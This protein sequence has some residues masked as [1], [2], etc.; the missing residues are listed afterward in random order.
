MIAA[1]INK[2]QELCKPHFIQLGEEHYVVDSDGRP[3]PIRLAVDYAEAIELYSLDALVR[4][5]ET[6]ALNLYSTPIYIEASDYDSVDCFLQP[7]GDLRFVRQELYNVAAKDIPG[8]KEEDSLPFEQALIAVRT[9]FQRS[10][11]TAYLLKLLSEISNGAKVTFA[12]NGI[13]TTVVTKKGIDLQASEAIRPIISLKPYRTFQLIEQ[14]ASEF[15]ILISERGIKFI[16]A[17]GGMWKLLAR[18]TIVNYL[19]ERLANAV[20]DGRVVV[21]L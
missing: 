21:M 15:H 16:E 2:I 7:N 18:Q 20:A 1:A 3:V 14:P 19:S 5:I 9:R 6:E 10:V 12:D 17:D 13:A 8:W 4:M 11:D